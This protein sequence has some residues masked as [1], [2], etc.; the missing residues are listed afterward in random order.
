MSLIF[1]E[2]TI[3]LNRIL[4]WVLL[5]LIVIIFVSGYALLGKI[6]I[7]NT[8]AVKMHSRLMIITIVLF[9]FHVT[10]GSMMLYYQRKAKKST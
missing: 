3:K 8:L 1:N 7:S 5:V 4:A 9:V 2:V 10:I 6:N